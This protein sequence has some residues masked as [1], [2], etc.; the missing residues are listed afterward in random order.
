ML[1]TNTLIFQPPRRLSKLWPCSPL[2]FPLNPGLIPPANLPDSL[3]LLAGRA[4]VARYPNLTR[5]REI[6]AKPPRHCRATADARWSQTS[7]ASGNY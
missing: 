6:T 7:K 5:P 2:P 3:V 1:V 4:L